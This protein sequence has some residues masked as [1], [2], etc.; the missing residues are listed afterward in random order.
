MAASYY[1][2]GGPS[3]FY[4]GVS[5]RFRETDFMPCPEIAA[6]S[7]AEWPFGYRELEPY[8]TEAERILD[9]AGT[10][11]QDPTEPFRSAPLSAELA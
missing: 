3:V 4:G 7:G 9:I 10:S 8:Y 5:L 11:G 2:V 6:G 1:C